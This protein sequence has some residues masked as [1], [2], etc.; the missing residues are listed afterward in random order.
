VTIAGSG[1]T[2]TSAVAFAGVSAA[3][4]I[5]DSDV[6]IRATVPAGAATGK[7]QVTN[8]A[9]SAQSAANFVVLTPTV[10]RL[11]PVQDSQ[12]KSTSPNSTY[13]SSTTL[14]AKSD[15]DIYDVYLKFTVSGVTSPL[16]SAVLQLYCSDASDDAGRLYAVANEYRGTTTPWVESGL[17]YNNAPA[18]SGT[19]LNSPVPAAAG[20][21]VQF[22]ATA[23]VSGNGT[24][25]FAIHNPSGNSVYYSS[26]EGDHPPVLVLTTGSTLLA[27]RETLSERA[28]SSKLG[29]EPNPGGAS[30][31]LRFELSHP[32]PNPS[33]GVTTVG[34]ALP[35][36]AVVTMA[37]IDVAGRVVRRIE[38]D[39]V[40]AG[41]H[42]ARW[43]GRDSSGRKAP[44]GV[45]FMRLQAG[46]ESRQQRI[47]FMP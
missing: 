28:G 39:R 7:I 19:P 33:R 9:G 26:K 38:F 42:Q 16:Q 44:S 5:V 23:V 24:W 17:N 43:D 1:F 4:F 13:G 25:S 10:L 11:A 27:Q 3:G 29:T 18:F 30:S 46:S 35:Y 32:F 2:A 15:S 14:R 40:A 36:P 41:M 6:Q 12:V 31:A 37:V 47:V 22:D 34:Y 21:W 45:Y 8:S 20:A